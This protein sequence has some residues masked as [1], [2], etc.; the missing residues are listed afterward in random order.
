MAL[1][2]YSDSESDGN[3]TKRRKGRGKS[4]ALTT[5]KPRQGDILPDKEEL[6]SLPDLPAEFRDLYT[7]N[8][9]ISVRDDPSLHD[10]RTRAVPHYV[11]NWPTHIYLECRFQV[12]LTLE[13]GI[14]IWVIG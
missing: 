11:G 9:R 1:V 14:N 13:S 8:S 12:I 2:E 3:T 5:K 7:S 10:G 4:P 6:S